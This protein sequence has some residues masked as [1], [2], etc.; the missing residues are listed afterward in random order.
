MRRSNTIKAIAASRVVTFLVVKLFGHLAGPMTDW[1]PNLSLKGMAGRMLTATFEI[2]EA[3]RFATQKA[4]VG[5]LET[6][7]ETL[8]VTSVMKLES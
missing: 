5:V 1:M 8:G 7:Y 2:L 6:R 4:V 3:T